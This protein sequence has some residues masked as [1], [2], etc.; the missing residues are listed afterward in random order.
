M[1]A[2]IIAS[3]GADKKRQS[4]EKKSKKR[5]EAEQC[6]IDSD[7]RAAVLSD[8]NIAGVVGQ[9]AFG[10]VKM[11]RHRT[12]GESCAVKVT[13]KNNAALALKEG[14]RVESECNTA[15]E[16]LSHP[17]ICRLYGTCWQGAD[18]PTVIAL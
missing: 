6:R 7:M 3:D 16:K 1:A 2:A 11:A 15:L 9:G 5:T 8:F 14:R 13:H 4:G 18:D 17:F 12:N 10:A